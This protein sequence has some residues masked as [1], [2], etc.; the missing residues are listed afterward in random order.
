MTILERTT[1]WFAHP[2]QQLRSAFIGILFVVPASASADSPAVQIYASFNERVAFVETAGTLHDDTIERTT[3]SGFLVGDRVVITN[4]HIIPLETNFKELKI[5]VRIGSRKSEAMT[6]TAFD[7][8]QNFDLAALTLAMPSTGVQSRS[9]P[10]KVMDQDPSVPIGSSVYVI[11]YPVDQDIS[12]SPGI[13][14]NKSGPRGRWQTSTPLNPGN[15]G[16]PAFG[17]SGMLIGF[18]VGGI[19]RWRSGDDIIAVQGVNFLI[20]TLSLIESPI[21]KKIDELPTGVKCWTLASKSLVL[22]DLLKNLSTFAS[23]RLS[24]TTSATG[25]ATCSSEAEKQ[26]GPQEF[27]RSYTV[28]QVKDDHPALTPDYR[29]YEERFSAEPGYKITQ[30]EWNSASEN[31]VEKISCAI[32]QGGSRANFTYRL[33]S[34][35]TFDRYRGWLYAT[36]TIRQQRD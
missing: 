32:E 6:V 14:S 36:V 27:A 25:I 21:L 35:P 15:S 18:A 11:G 13:I 16:G 17:E 28:T 29:A 4:N 12:I 24:C 30:C 23:A 20:P 8:D 3:G 1:A 10:I 26:K 2:R 9:C 34:G 31:H 7:R 19:V 33:F 22:T 5:S